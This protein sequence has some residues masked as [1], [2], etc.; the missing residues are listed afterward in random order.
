MNVFFIFPGRSTGKEVPVFEEGCEFF[1]L[2]TIQAR[3]VQFNPIN[4]TGRVIIKK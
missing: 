4:S 3:T 1:S 2:E